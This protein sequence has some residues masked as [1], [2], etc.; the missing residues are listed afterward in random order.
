MISRTAGDDFYI[1]RVWRQVSIS[2]R[3]GEPNDIVVLDAPDWVNVLAITPQLEVIMI[4]Q[5]RH[6]TGEV[7]VELPGGMIDKGE[8][9]LVAGIRELR[10]ETGYAG[11]TPLL[12][13]KVNPNPAFLSNKCYTVLI[14]DVQR[15][16]EMKLDLGED[17]AVRLVP[18]ADV[19]GQIASGEIEHSL[20]ITAF[21]W[22]HVA[23]PELMP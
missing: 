10:E 23:A 6:G 1:F 7:G 11:D 12:L 9:P 15:V 14:R 3:T 21:H 20:V 4:D 22:L 17:I 5:Y 16:G 8:S 13:G 2:P 18:L 19:P